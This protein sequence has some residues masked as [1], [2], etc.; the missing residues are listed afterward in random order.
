MTR[1]AHCPA[2]HLLAAAL[3]LATPCVALG[4]TPPPPKGK[5]GARGISAARAATP[6]APA[7][8]RVR[9]VL[10]A[11]FLPSSLDYSSLST[12]TAYAEPSS[13]RTSYEAGSGFGPGAALQVSLYRGFGIL[14]GYSKVTRD[15]TGT[16]DVSRPHPLHLNRPRTASAE[17]SG[18]G[19][20]EGAI[21]I[22]LAYARSADS[23]DW[24]LFGG[25]T[26][27][28]VEAD[29]LGAP[30]FGEQYP[31]DELTITATPATAVDESATGFNVGGRLD[32]R[33]GSTKRFGVGV[34]VRYSSASVALVAGADAAETTLDLGGFSVGG[35]VRIYF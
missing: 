35:G 9:L 19:Y 2:P 3:L 28:S 17:L 8:T 11:V 4:Q 30:T 34:T 14:A 22:D 25:V 6:A 10:D 24:A 32:Y 1:L 26:L 21:D 12:P 16:L 15:V 18:Y 31:Y 20:S 29:L 23:L 5:P 13:I 7:E 27:F 33:F